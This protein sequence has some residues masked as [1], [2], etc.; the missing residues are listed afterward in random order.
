V[1]YVAQFPVDERTDGWS[2][3][4]GWLGWLGRENP[5]ARPEK[6]VEF[7][8]LDSLRRGRWYSSGA[9]GGKEHG[10]PEERGGRG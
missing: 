5:T 10:E 1:V 7:D 4:D 8:K 9:R 3:W 2:G 6:A